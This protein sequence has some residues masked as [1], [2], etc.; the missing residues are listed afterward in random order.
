MRDDPSLSLVPLH[1]PRSTRFF[2]TYAKI[3]FGYRIWQEFPN[4]LVGYESAS[5]QRNTTDGLWE[6]VPA[7]VDRN[8]SIVL[9]RAAFYHRLATCPHTT[10]F[11]YSCETVFVHFCPVLFTGFGRYYN[12]LYW[13]T[14]ESKL[15]EIV[16]VLNDCED[17]LLNTLIAHVS[18]APPVLVRSASAKQRVLPAEYAVQRSACLQAFS[19]SFSA[20]SSVFWSLRPSDNITPIDRNQSVG[21]NGNSYLPL[22]YASYR[23]AL[24]F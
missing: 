5:H 9:L 10:L 1:F 24:L 3:E 19:E 15:H 14:A 20:S 7:R 12:Y 13:L 22:Y 2:L 11:A 18:Q 4:R 6:Y 17:L 21:A 23:Y 8:Y 16:G